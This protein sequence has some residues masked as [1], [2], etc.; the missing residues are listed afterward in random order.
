MES[1][2]RY[3]MVFPYCLKMFGGTFLHLLF[4]MLVYQLLVLFLP[5]RSINEVNVS[6]ITSSHTYDSKH[7]RTLLSGCPG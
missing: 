3:F 5:T 4:I 2:H 7:T 1:E 6:L